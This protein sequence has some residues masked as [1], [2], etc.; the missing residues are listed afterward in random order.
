MRYLFFR[1]VFVSVE[2]LVLGGGYFGLWFVFLI[3]LARC[4][5][6]L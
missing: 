4:R 3:V 5:E 6:A 1:V 2:G